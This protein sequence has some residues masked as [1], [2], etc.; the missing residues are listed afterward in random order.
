MFARVL[1]SLIVLREVAIRVNSQKVFQWH[2]W[3]YIIYIDLK[4]KLNLVHNSLIKCMLRYT[5]Y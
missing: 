4:A 5:M 1:C 3:I 2:I